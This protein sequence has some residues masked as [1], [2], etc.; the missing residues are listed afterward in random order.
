VQSTLDLAKV[1]EYVDAKT[2]GSI[3][4]LASDYLVAFGI[5]SINVPIVLTHAVPLV[6]FALLGLA[7]CVGWLL[8]VAP[9]VFGPRWFE[10]GIFAYGWNTA[11]I[12]FGV[13]LLRIVDRRGDSKVL[14]DYG[15]A[16]IAI[17]PLEAILYTSVLAALANGE[18]LALGVGLV[19]AAIVMAVLAVASGGA[20]PP[21]PQ[22]DSPQNR[23]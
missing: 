4:S 3:G 13:A 10:P 12:A 1:G 7:I 19:V 6:V 15:V 11:T 21:G 8:L 5:A 22:G 23:A 14:S 18:L 17:G 9:R 16:Y 20:R 2:I